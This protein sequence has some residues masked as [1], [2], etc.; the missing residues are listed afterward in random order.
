MKL[1]IRFF[2]AGAIL[3]GCAAL[4]GP[5]VQMEGGELDVIQVRPNFYMI[6][7]AGGNIAVQL[8]PAG[9]IL[10]DTGRREMSEKVLAAIGRLTSGRIRYIINTSSDP[11]HI[12][13]NEK[14]SQAGQTILGN[15]G[16]SGV[17]EQVYTNGGAA[18]ILAYENV[19][20]RMSAPTGQ[21]SL[22]PFAAWPT[23]TYTGRAYPMY[24]NGDGIQV[25]HA[26]DAHS[27]GDSMVFFR[28][29]DVI[30]TGD[31][32]DITRFPVIDVTK[33]GSIQGEIDA[34][35]RLV[36]MTIPPFPL[37]YREDRTYLIPGHGFVCDYSDL[38]QYRTM[39]IIIRDRIQDMIDRNM[40]L[41]Q[42]KAADP[43]QGFKG[44]YGR[45]GGPGM[46]DMF[47][48]AIYSSLPKDKTPR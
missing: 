26:P 18:S 33:G 7:G 16:S 38:V 14:L 27:D 45:E 6:A 30:V 24:F 23:K 48:E 34:L 9:A 21:Q 1:L 8:G 5:I 17:S 44:R 39:V 32:L 35:N 25:L 36:E 37:A 42:V 41:Q 47:V 31:I 13:G 20:T 2:I 43:T 46:T 12:G 11:D 40:T 3:L 4:A 28:R 19:L 15:P 22:F 29:A 10:V